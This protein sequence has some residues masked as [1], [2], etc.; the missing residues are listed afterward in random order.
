MDRDALSLSDFVQAKRLPLTD[1]ADL[2]MLADT[3][4]LA[5][6]A[7][8][9]ESL[10]IESAAKVLAKVRIEDYRESERLLESLSDA[11][12]EAVGLR[13]AKPSAT[14]VVAPFTSSPPAPEQS[15]HHAN[16]L[17]RRCPVCGKHRAG[18]ESHIRDAHGD[19]VLERLKASGD[20]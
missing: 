9:L 16:G 15:S 4:S 10:D 11:T 14:P 18:L 17:A 2:L 12:R 5:D 7:R 1:I 20:V 19:T 13:F 3:A 6:K 8:V